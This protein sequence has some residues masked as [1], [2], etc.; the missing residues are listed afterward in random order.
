MNH[1]ADLTFERLYT[2]TFQE[3]NLLFI[4]ILRVESIFAVCPHT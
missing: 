4:T 2:V 3:V 1:Q